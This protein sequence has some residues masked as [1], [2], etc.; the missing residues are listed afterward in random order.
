MKKAPDFERNI[1]GILDEQRKDL[2]EVIIT[3]N[4]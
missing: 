4:K 3:L 1:T 2:K